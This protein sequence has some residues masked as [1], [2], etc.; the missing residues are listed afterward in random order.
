MGSVAEEF[1][2]KFVDNREDGVRTRVYDVLAE[3]GTEKSIAKLRSNIGKE[4]DTFMK[5]RCKEVIELIKTRGE[6]S[7]ATTDPNSPFAT[8]PKK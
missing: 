1:V 6:E 7:K 2:I 3:I 5:D 8:K 4:K